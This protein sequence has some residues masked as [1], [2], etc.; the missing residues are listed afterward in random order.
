MGKGVGGGGVETD[1]YDYFLFDY[2]YRE[3]PRYG[4]SSTLRG[5]SC[6]PAMDIRSE[7]RKKEKKKRGFIS[8]S[9]RLLC[10]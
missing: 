4:D 1:K 7:K 2:L 6:I 8:P 9:C 10:T 3:L 5:S